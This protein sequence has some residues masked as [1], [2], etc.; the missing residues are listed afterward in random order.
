MNTFASVSAYTSLRNGMVVSNYISMFNEIKSAA[1]FTSSKSI[2][3]Y[4]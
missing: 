2:D 3:I 4:L 1:I